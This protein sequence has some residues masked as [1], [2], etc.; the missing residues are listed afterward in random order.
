MERAAPAS[1]R[2]DIPKEPVERL[3]EP[4]KTPPG[5]ENKMTPPGLENKM[6]DIL[7]EMKLKKRQPTLYNSPRAAYL[8]KREQIRN[9]LVERFKNTLE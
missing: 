3:V 4:L 9:P 7:Q 5:L 6:T 8:N 2:N 1:S